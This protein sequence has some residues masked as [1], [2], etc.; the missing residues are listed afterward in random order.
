STSR[1]T[2][3]QISPRYFL[4]S[5]TSLSGFFF[6]SP[7]LSNSWHATSIDQPL[8]ITDLAKSYLALH[9][10]CTS[11]WAAVYSSITRKY[12]SLSTPRL[13]A[14]IANNSDASN[15]DKFADI[16]SR[17]IFLS[18]LANSSSVTPSGF[19]SPASS[20][21]VCGCSTVKGSLSCGRVA[22]LETC[23]IEKF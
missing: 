11:F 17:A 20:S 19:G 12:C 2:D 15:S 21:S 10:L 16:P 9:N 8:S 1:L 5:T 18:N 7:V 14:S 23:K 4:A 13:F 22:N 3:S 6:S